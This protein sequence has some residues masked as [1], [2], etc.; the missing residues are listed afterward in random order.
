MVID[1][2]YLARIQDTLTQR[3]TDLRAQMQQVQG[4][5][6]LVEQQRVYLKEPLP[7]APSD[8]AAVEAESP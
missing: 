5:L 2:A 4:A 7:D 1:D 3:V 8:A 6:A